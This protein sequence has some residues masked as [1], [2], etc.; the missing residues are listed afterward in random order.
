[1]LW[2]P[3]GGTPGPANGGPRSLFEEVGTPANLGQTRRKTPDSNNSDITVA[4]SVREMSEM[5]KW[6]HRRVA[7]P[8][9]ANC[10]MLRPEENPLR[11]CRIISFHQ[12]KED[13]LNLKV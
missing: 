4:H 3:R 10:Q 11:V 7:V 13:Q 1:M 8:T 5:M 6:G 2:K 12:E 9:P